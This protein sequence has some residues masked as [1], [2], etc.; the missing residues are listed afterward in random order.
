MNKFNQLIPNVSGVEVDG[1]PALFLAYKPGNFR[2][3]NVKV[4]LFYS[5]EPHWVEESKVNV[6]P[7]QTHTFI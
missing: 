6:S 3:Q 1:V 2:Q 4:K 5:K 7:E